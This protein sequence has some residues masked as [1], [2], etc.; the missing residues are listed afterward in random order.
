MQPDNIICKNI[1]NLGPT[2]C[3]CKEG[4][5][6]QAQLLCIGECSVYTNV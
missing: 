6:E 3:G 5:Q 4:L 1:L 2:K